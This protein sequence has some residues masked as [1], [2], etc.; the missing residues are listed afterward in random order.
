MID[1][2]IARTANT[3]KTLRIGHR[4]ASGHSHENT[5]AS[6][7]MAI[8][9]GVDM[10]ELD[11]HVCKT[12]EVVVIHDKTVNRTTNG[13]GLVHHMTLA[14]LKLLRIGKEDRIPLL[15][16]VFDLVDRRIAINIE[17]KGKDTA[18]AVSELITHYVTAKGWQ[19]DDFLV[20]SFHHT[21][22]AAIK[23]CNTQIPRAFLL[24]R[25]PRNLATIIELFSPAAINLNFKRVKQAFVDKVH[26]AGIKVIV[27]TVNDEKDIQRM[28]NFGVDG[29]I[30]DYPD[31]LPL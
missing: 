24:E 20:S 7:D 16:E 4:G 23:A 9:Y 6:F 29:I 17:L 10:I 25:S 21:Q 13:I 3:K 8:K 19:Y 5:L 12:G 27:W 28:T 30:T 11:V 22:L 1:S 2:T 15:S 18:S 31:R 14:E 26:Q